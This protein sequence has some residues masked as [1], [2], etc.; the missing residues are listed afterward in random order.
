MPMRWMNSKFIHGQ[1]EKILAL[2]LP[3]R[4]DRRDTLTLTA[5][6]NDIQLEWINAV[7]GDDLHRKAWPAV[8]RHYLLRNL[9]PT[10]PNDHDSTGIRVNSTG[11]WQSL[12]IGDRMSMSCEGVY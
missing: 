12:V 10:I 2:G 8:R 11:R 4:S 5:A 3:E 7:K 1:F 6:V 9:F